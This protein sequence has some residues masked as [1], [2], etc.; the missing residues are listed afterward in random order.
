MLRK[1]NLSLMIL[2]ILTE[3]VSILLS[4]KVLSLAIELRSD[5]LIPDSN[6]MNI[7]SPIFALIQVIIPFNL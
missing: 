1:T 6:I 5:V 3:I 2:I 7:L 4:S